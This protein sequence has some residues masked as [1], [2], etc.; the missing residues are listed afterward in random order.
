M[1]DLRN[2]LHGVLV[3]KPVEMD[4]TQREDFVL[5]LVHNTVD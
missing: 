3:L 2:G 1:E 5:T 4:S